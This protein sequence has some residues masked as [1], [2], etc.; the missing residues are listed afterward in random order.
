M[1]LKKSKSINILSSNTKIL[2]LL[3]H[4]DDEFAIL[5]FLKNLLKQNL[6]ID[7]IYCAERLEENEKA[8]L[9]REENNTVLSAMGVCKENIIYL[10]DYMEIGD[11]ELYKSSKE[12]YGFVINR[13]MSIKYDTVITL[14]LE[15]G[16][17][18]HDALAL[19]VKKITDSTKLDAMYF[20]A[21]NYDTTFFLLPVRVLEPLDTQKKYFRHY[22][23]SFMAWYDSL[24]CLINYSTE[25]KATIKLLPFILIKTFLSKKIWYSKKIELESINWQKSLTQVNYKIPF[26]KIED[27][28]NKIK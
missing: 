19:I 1:F 7:I 28:I 24:K 5:P 16:H 8:L 9:R 10:N 4:L 18:D 13:H 6:L 2:I 12:I 14:S 20:P 11:L 15:G 3:P 22:R 17:P 25:R 23:L 21:Y 27:Q 26:K